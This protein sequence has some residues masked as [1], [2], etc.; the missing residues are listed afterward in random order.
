MKLSSLFAALLTVTGAA[1]A[2]ESFQSLSVYYPNTPWA[3]GTVNNWGKTALVA[4]SAYKYTGVSYVGYVNV[5]SGSQQIKFDTSLDGDWS[6]SYGDNNAA[7]NCL[8]LNG[9]NLPIVQGAGTYELRYS[10]G[11]AGYGCGRPFVQI[12][13]LNSYVANVRSLYLRTSF[14]SWKPLPMMLARSHVWEAEVSGTP[15]TAGN[16]KFDQFGDWSSSFG[17]PAGSDPRSYT[18]TGYA[19]ARNGDNLGLHMEDYSGATTVT[20]KVRFNDQTNEFAVCRDATR[21]I[22]Q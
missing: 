22:C 21:P 3:R 12:T 2:Y 9:P 4:A 1:N 6:T 16:M 19:V 10:T 11:A 5:L 8:D 13:K 18:N 17:R 7:D 15:N 20:V 14:N